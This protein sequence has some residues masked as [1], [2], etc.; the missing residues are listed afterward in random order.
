MTAKTG[1]RCPAVMST[2]AR[3]KLAAI[4]S[5]RVAGRT[6]PAADWQCSREPHTVDQGPTHDVHLAL[7]LGVTGPSVRFD[8]QTVEPCPTCMGPT[9][10]TVG[11]VCQTCG[12][13]YGPPDEQPATEAAPIVHAFLSDRADNECTRLL[14]NGLACGGTPHDHAQPVDQALAALNTVKHADPDDVRRLIELVDRPGT[15]AVLVN[16]GDELLLLLP[17][18]G[19]PARTAAASNTLTQLFPTVTFLV[20]SGVTGAVL[21]PKRQKPASTYANMLASYEH[22]IAQRDAL[23]MQGVNPDE[24][25]LPVRPANPDAN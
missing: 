2:D 13:D 23:I 12:R 22:L 16:D 7:P 9:R 21:M 18:E 4:E 25:N 15:T 20:L 24:L 6:P 5:A 19:D 10:E 11:M 3:P 17:D 14:P 1:H 8:D